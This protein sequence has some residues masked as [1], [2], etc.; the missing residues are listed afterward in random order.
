MILIIFAANVGLGYAIA[1]HMLADSTVHVLL[2]ARSAEKGQA[3]VKE[4][5]SQ[6]LPGAVELLQ[7][8][9]SKED[10]IAQ[11]AKTVKEKFGKYAKSSVL[12]RMS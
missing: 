3:A 11:A 9:V 7:I 8:D 4:L 1:E 2:G 5:Q 10:S 12:T 6:D